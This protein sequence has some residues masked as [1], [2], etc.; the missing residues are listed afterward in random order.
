[1]KSFTLLALLFLATFTFAE[2]T[3]ADALAFLK[4]HAPEILNDITPLKTSDPADYQS[5][6]DDAKKATAEFAIIEAAGDT[7]AMTAYVKMYTLDYQAIDTADQLIAAKDE[8]EKVVLTTK[9]TELITASFDQWALVEQARVTRL[10]KE[11]TNLKAD[12]SQAVGHR[13]EVIEKDTAKLI[14][15]CRAYQTGKAKQN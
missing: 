15:E 6:L 13:A 9:L 10:E 3:E 2:V 11:L 14:E 1:M 4:Q 8:K 12:L 7:T 5:A